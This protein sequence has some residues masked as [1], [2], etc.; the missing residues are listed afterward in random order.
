MGYV[1]TLWQH[2]LVVGEI[3]VVLRYASPYIVGTA[4]DSN[5]FENI[6]PVLHSINWHYPTS[7]VL[8]WMEDCYMLP[9]EGFTLWS[10]LVIPPWVIFRHPRIQPACIPFLASQASKPR[11]EL[12]AGRSGQVR[13]ERWGYVT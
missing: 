5:T 12:K 1:G 7:F 13:S 11:G 9:N 10:S 4:N 3:L 6:T 2:I 8:D